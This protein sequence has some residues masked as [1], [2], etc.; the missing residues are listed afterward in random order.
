MA[1][2]QLLEVQLE[3]LRAGPMHNQ[4]LSPLTPYLALCG[5][6][7]A[8][9]FHIPMEHREL[10]NRLERLR[11]L[12]VDRQTKRAVRMDDRMREGELE[13][14]GRF[15]GE[16]LSNIKTLGSELSQTKLEKGQ[17]VH[18]RL[19]LSG[20]EL[21]LIPFELATSPLGL[22]GEGMPLVL[23]KHLPITMTREARRTPPTDMEWVRLPRVLYISA[24]PSGTTPVPA[25]G[26]CRAIRDALEPWI[27]WNP[28]PEDRVDHV[29]E[30][31]TILQ[32]ATLE[33]I[34][35]KCIGKRYTHVHIL[36]HGSQYEKAGERRFGIA[37]CTED[38]PNGMDVV[39]GERL[40][41]A[42]RAA[43][44][45]DHSCSNPTVVTLM[46]CDSGNQASVISPGGSIAHDLHAYGI[47]WVFASQ[48]PL[49]I[50]GST[51]IAKELYRALFRGDDPRCI[52]HALRNM[53][54]ANSEENHDWA[55]LVA[56]VRI[57]NDFGETLR[58]FR[59]RQRRKAIDIAFDK[60]ERIMEYYAGK[61]MP[62]EDRSA[63]ESKIEGV[64]LEVR[65][66][67]EDWKKD[68][69]QEVEENKGWWSEYFGLM[70]AHEKR[71]A[72]LNDRRGH[73]GEYDLG[74]K[75]ALQ[76]YRKAFEIDMSN[77]WTATQCLSLATIIDAKTLVDPNWA[78]LIRMGA[79]H[80]LM[81]PLHSKQAWGHG[82]L[83]ELEMLL[84]CGSDTEGVKETVV[85]HCRSIQELA[86]ERSFHV[87]STRRQFKRYLDHWKKDQWIPIARAAY[88]VLCG[89]MGDESYELPPDP[90]ED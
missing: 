78:V 17:G 58:S 21:S 24:A 36:A 79:E 11:Y 84:S 23:Q 77:H 33:K 14:L 41:Q 2:N 62:N 49:T 61:A 86:G 90:Y 8:V 10:I 70:G 44:S 59:E 43:R 56:Y 51:R 27:R 37:L 42:L 9:N 26:H 52:L 35:E 66:H 55:S 6:G 81:S 20:S 22:P 69:P 4:L 13:E 29:A 32:D 64:I 73:V 48:F 15:V 57:P 5:D 7:G 31:L 85:E 40:A 28:N 3:I 87:H 63:G 76:N 45:E 12:F 54:R 72:L 89:D 74:L 67:M 88:E 75:K 19:V 71:I 80:D 82:T 16:L 46:T 18:L 25:E 83:A 30:R 65:A 38:D 60:A 39:S 68:L 53:L 1:M 50:S 47:P 34:R